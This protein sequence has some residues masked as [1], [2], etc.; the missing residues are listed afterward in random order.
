[1]VVKLLTQRFSKTL[2]WTLLIHYTFSLRP[3]SFMLIQE[4]RTCIKQRCSLHLRVSHIIGTIQISWNVSPL[5]EVR[6]SETWLATKVL[7]LL[8]WW[9]FI[10]K[11]TSLLSVHG[12][13]F[14]KGISNSSDTVRA[15]LTHNT[16]VMNSN[17]RT[18]VALVGIWC[19]RFNVFLWVYND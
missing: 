14:S 17:P 7:Y 8:D 18:D 6:I 2:F 10:Q 19:Q 16:A 1:M 12:I 5:S 3:S 15:N 11:M 4:L 9:P 13:Q